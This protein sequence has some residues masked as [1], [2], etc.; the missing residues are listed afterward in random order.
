LPI[1]EKVAAIEEALMAA[2]H[3]E[4]DVSALARWF[5]G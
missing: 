5:M 3:G 1:S 2:G 4:E